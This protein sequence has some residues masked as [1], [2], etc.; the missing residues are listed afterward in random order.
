METDPTKQGA[1]WLLNVSLP[2][3]YSVEGG[4]VERACS[5]LVDPSSECVAGA[6]EKN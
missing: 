4:F 3:T 6:K 5:V 1:L 2:N